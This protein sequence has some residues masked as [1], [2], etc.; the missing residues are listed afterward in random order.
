VIKL[1]E[2]HYKILYLSKK[3]CHELRELY[4]D[5]L[6]FKMLD[7]C[8][9]EIVKVEFTRYQSIID[10]K[11]INIAIWNINEDQIEDNISLTLALRGTMAIFYEPN[12]SEDKGMKFV[13]ECKRKNSELIK[14]IA[15]M[16]QELMNEKYRSVQ[17]EIKEMIDISDGEIILVFKE[18]KSA[19]EIL[20]ALHDISK[21]L[22]QIGTI[23]SRIEMLRF[24]QE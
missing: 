22:I 3:Y 14:R 7:F 5:D 15:R 18:I 20:P 1:D 23:M 19:D 4:S 12:L 21:K 16:T 6:Y 17:R 13:S 9:I 10:G 2:F 11:K 24:F 8:S